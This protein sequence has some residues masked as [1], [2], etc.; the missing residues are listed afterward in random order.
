[1]NKAI[2]QYRN[3]NPDLPDGG[4]FVFWEGRCCGWKLELTRP[5]ND[6]P[7]V[8][9]VTET[10]EVYKAVGGDDFNGAERWEKR[11]EVGDDPI[12]NSDLLAPKKALG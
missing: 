9:A 5:E 4:Y 6:R 11:K 8:I 3:N 12:V 1:M 2:K 10:G 7:G